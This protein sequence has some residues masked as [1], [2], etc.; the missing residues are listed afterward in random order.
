MKR[1]TTLATAVAAA[2]VASTAAHAAT[3]VTI[4]AGF[5]GGAVVQKAQSALGGTSQTWSGVLGQFSINNI[6]GTFSGA[7]LFA[8]NVQNTYK[9]AAANPA[10]STLDVFV[11]VTGLTG[12]LGGIT[13]PATF[14]TYVTSNFLASGWSVTEQTWLDP[15]NNINTGSSLGTGTFGPSITSMTDHFNSLTATGAGPYSITT[16]YLVTVNRNGIPLVNPKKPKGPHTQFTTDN[17]TTDVFG[18]PGV[19]P[20]PGTWALMILGFGG[21]GALLR[22]RRR[23]IATA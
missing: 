23:V 13:H 17:L 22:N 2:L 7:P 16:E 20:E 5:N 21:V 15:N 1:F 18:T 12:P 9:W 8:T 11:S 6:S 19:V 4:S 10:T 14:D 3:Q